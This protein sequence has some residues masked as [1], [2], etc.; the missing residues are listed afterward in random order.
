MRARTI[1]AVIENS[2][3]RHREE[4]L[5]DNNDNKRKKNDEDGEHNNGVILFFLGRLTIEIRKH[6]NGIENERASGTEERGKS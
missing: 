1:V 3:F 6:R 2:R 4:E 5:C